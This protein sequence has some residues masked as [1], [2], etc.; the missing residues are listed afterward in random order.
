MGRT[1]YSKFL[2]LSV[3]PLVLMGAAAHAQEQDSQGRDHKAKPDDN[4]VVVVTANRQK[5]DVQK[6]S[7]AVQV[8]SGEKLREQALVNVEQIFTSTPSVQAT[9]QPAG[10]NVDIRGQAADQPSSSGQGSVA[11]EFDGIYNLTSY[12]TTVG[13]FDIGRVEILPGPQSTQ[14]GPNAKGGVVNV[15]SRDPVFGSHH[16]DASV[17]IGDYGLIRTELAQDIPV[18]DT[19]A[20]RVSGATI[21]RDS[22]FKPATGDAVGQSGRVRLLW[23]PTEHLTIKAQYQ[24]DHIGGTGDGS[25]AGA[26]FYAAFV[27]PYVDGS[28]N[29]TSNPWHQGDYSNDPNTSP[30]KTSTNILQQTL[31]GSLSYQFAPHA[32]VDLTE[33]YIKDTGK[34]YDCEP[35]TFA[36]VG[37]AH[38][39]Y[40]E[41]PFGPYHSN[42]TEVR[43][44]NTQ[45]SKLLWNL[46]YYNWSYLD[47]AWSTNVPPNITNPGPQYS[48]L[49][50]TTTN[51]I[52]GQLTYPVTEQLRLI[53]GGRQSWDSRELTPGNSDLNLYK[54]HYK[55]FD[56]RLGEEYDITPNSMEYFTVSTGYEPGAMSTG[57]NNA[58]HYGLVVNPNEDLK[59]YELG[60]KNQF[61]HHRVTFN[62][63]GF[64]YVQKHYAFG[65]SYSGFTLPDGTQ[66][67]YGSRSNPAECNIPH[68][69]A[70]AHTRGIEMQLNVRATHADDFGLTATYLNAT[71]DKNQAACNTLDLPAGDTGC[72]LGTNLSDGTLVWHNISGGVQ[73]HAPELVENFSYNH[74]FELGSGARIRW[75]G[76][77]F[78]S[79]SYWEMPVY[80]SRDWFQ[81]AYYLFNTTVSYT[82]AKGDWR[83]SGYIRNIGNYAVKT[84]G[85][86]ATTIGDPRTI[87]VTL[88]KQW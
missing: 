23:E 26:P 70:N 38:T 75:G 33:A 48:S 42:S 78:H 24:A 41:Y 10:F 85:M 55:N 58:G 80:D 40:E 67:P 60:L 11:M 65:S 8:I 59:A 39:C 7:S 16:G 68:A 83:I 51:A 69:I 29:N 31:W 37:G 2:A 6:V 87:G 74:T 30:S 20:I 79:S 86:P 9:A 1:R 63:D 62:I 17:T 81:P 47:K 66:C 73:D 45:G 3:A 12:A 52:Y 21:N 15:I 49:A 25:E 22:Y 57:T 56:Y 43:F 88:S 82:P 72:W 53:A 77:I 50:S 35:N 27:N 19:L 46:G 28:I 54:A 14:Y 5:Q 61:F 71:Y 64:I 13:F 44:H 84:S 76:E 32:A 34:Q 18:S 4:T 36:T